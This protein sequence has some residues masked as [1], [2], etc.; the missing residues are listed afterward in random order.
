MQYRVGIIGM[1]KDELEQDCQGT[2][3]QLAEWGYEGIESPIPLIQKYEGKLAELRHMLDDL[4]LAVVALPCSH[5]KEDELPQTIRQAQAL[6]CKF[7]VDYWSGPETKE[8]ALETAAQLERM[9]ETC[10]AEG[11]TFIY[12]NHEHEFIP[13]LGERRNECIFDIYYQNT[14]KLK[15][16]LDIAWCRFAKADPV[17]V[18]RSYGERIPVMHIKDLAHDYARGHF[19]AVGTGIVDCYSAIEAGAA[20]GVEWMVVEQDKPGILSLYESAMVS[21]MNLR[22][23]G[24][25]R[26]PANK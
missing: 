5:Y 7:V 20:Q 4:G 6:G 19:T 17:R 14:E 10:A 23:V 11:L 13:K 18:L 26:N 25:A 3:R 8:E 1:I 12:H 9:A 2:L 22:E 15:F 24:L 16:Q 21:I